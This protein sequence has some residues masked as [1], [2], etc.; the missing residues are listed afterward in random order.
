MR[1]PAPPADPA[2]AAVAARAARRAGATLSVAVAA[3]G[4]VAGAAVGVLDP[5]ALLAA[6]AA[7]AAAAAVARAVYGDRLSACVDLDG[8]HVSLAPPWRGPGPRPDGRPA[9]AVTPAPSR[10]GRGVVATSPVPAGAFLGT[11]EGDLLDT[12]SFWAR[13][14][15]GVA[16]YTIAV[17]PAWAIDGERLAQGDSPPYS[18]CLVNHSARRPNAARVVRVADRAVDLYA[19]RDIEP[20]EEVLFDY[21]DTYWTGREGAVVD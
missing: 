13:H 3:A 20:G 9:L 5:R 12:R 18:P 6:A 21:G 10:R 14:P 8:V 19:S 17:G 7:P 2:A 16:D 4:A 15:S 1:P 11:Y